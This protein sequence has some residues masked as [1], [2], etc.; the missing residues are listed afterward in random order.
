MIFALQV[1]EWKFVPVDLQP[2]KLCGIVLWFEKESIVIE[3]EL[4]E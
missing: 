1:F 2:A 3:E 4:G